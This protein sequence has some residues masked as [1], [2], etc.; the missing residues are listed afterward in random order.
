MVG[1]NAIR[2]LRDIDVLDDVLANCEEPEIDL[3]TF[4]FYSGMEGHELIFNVRLYC[5]LA[6]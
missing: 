6:Q 2:V 4:I 3:R 1:P 5:T